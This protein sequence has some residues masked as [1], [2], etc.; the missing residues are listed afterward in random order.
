MVHFRFSRTDCRTCPVRARCTQSTTLPRAVT[1]YAQPAYDALQAA[2]QRQHTE[3]FWQQYA[4]RAGIEGT[5]AQGNAR[6]DLRHAR[7]IG[8]AKTHLQHVCTALGLNVL[9]VG[10]W[11]ADAAPR[12]TTSRSSFAALAPAGI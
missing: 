3:T 11:L 12:H 8:L 4:S 2:R 6:A 1:I 9:R 7:F 5:M 10:N